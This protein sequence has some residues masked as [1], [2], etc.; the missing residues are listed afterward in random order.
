MPQPAAGFC[1]AL[2]CKGFKPSSNVAMNSSRCKAACPFWINGSKNRSIRCVWQAMGH[3]ERLRRL[4]TMGVLVQLG[5][6]LECCSEGASFWDD[7]EDPA[8]TPAR[9]G[10]H[11][12]S[13]LPCLSRRRRCIVPHLCPAASFS[14]AGSCVMPTPW[15]PYL[16][17]RQ[18]L[19]SAAGRCESQ[20][21]PCRLVERLETEAPASPAA[22]PAPALESR[23][24]AACAGHS[25]WLAAHGTGCAALSCLVRG[26]EHLATCPQKKWANLRN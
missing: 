21:A 1:C 11:A 12:A 4:V 23:V 5:M 24:W 3:A 25:L 19:P 6:S 15:G 8:R 26:G 16:P 14:G 17:L 18:P 20:P 22:C 10:S 7:L 2:R 13:Q 9:A